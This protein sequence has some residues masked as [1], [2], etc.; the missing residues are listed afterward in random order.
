MKC[1]LI[2]TAIVYTLFVWKLLLSLYSHGKVQISQQT[3]N[4]TYLKKLLHRWRILQNWWERKMR[5]KNQRYSSTW[6]ASHIVYINYLI[7]WIFFFL[8]S[9]GLIFHIHAIDAL[10]CS[11]FF[12]FL[13]SHLICIYVYS[14]IRSI[15]NYCWHHNRVQRIR[16]LCEM[17]FIII[18]QLCQD[19]RWANNI[20]SSIASANECVCLCVL[21][22][23]THIDLQWLVWFLGEGC[24][25]YDK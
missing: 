9:L 21:G 5:M 8:L 7:V 19:R 6:I 25:S 20:D 10:E 13:L 16:W 12:F 4:A 3:R 23:N 22:L 18:I 14:C 24:S 11:I 1:L 2:L 17:A 15:Y